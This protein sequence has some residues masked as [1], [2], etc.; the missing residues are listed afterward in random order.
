[1]HHPLILL[2]VQLIDL[3]N[4]VIFAW[5]IIN[6]LVYF[7]II[8]AYQPLVRK[9][10]Q[11]LNQVIEPILRPIRNILPPIAGLDL[12]PVILIIGLQFLRNMLIYYF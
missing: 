1:M 9:I 11:V 12:S 5:V 10:I 3:F 7:N 2:L 8:N 4:L 6:L